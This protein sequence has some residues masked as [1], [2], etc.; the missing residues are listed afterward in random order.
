[1]KLLLKK[2]RSISIFILAISLMG[3][4]DDDENKLPKVV[5]GF[6]QTIDEDTGTTTFINIST[7]ANTYLWDFGDEETSTEIN[8]VKS[9]AA[10]GTYTVT[11]TATNLAGLSD[12]S[13]AELI[14]VIKDL[15]ALPV[16]F[17]DPNVIYEAT[18][19]EGASFDVVDN[20]DPSG[21][22]ADASQVGEITNSG[23]AFEGL[24]FDLGA[25]LDLATDQT[26][27]MDFW[28]EAVLEVLIK[29][30][31]GSGSDVE[32]SAS[33]SGSG[34]ET[35]YF[36]FTSVDKFSRMTLFVDGPGTAAGTFYFD[37][38][39]QTATICRDTELGLPIDF[40]CESTTY[41]FVTTS[42]ATYQVI[43][44]PELSG[45]NNAATNV[46]EIVTT[47]SAGGTFTLDN[48]IDL[49]TVAAVS[50]KMFSATGASATVKLENATTSVETVVVHGGTGWERL[51]FNYTAS[52]EMYDMVTLTVDAAGTYYV[53]DI[54]QSDGT[55]VTPPVVTIN[56]GVSTINL[57]VGDLFTDP[58]ATA[59]DDEDGPVAVVVTGVADVDVNTVGS[60]DVI[61][62]ATDAAGNIGQAT[63]T[64]IVSAAAGCTDTILEV[65]IDFDCESTTYDFVTFNGAS[66]QVIDNPQLS[67]INNVASKVGEIVNIGGGFEGGAFTLGNPV[68]FSTDKSITMKVYATVAVP[69]LLKF[70]GA[71]APIET[72][73]NHGGSG[74]EQLTFDFASSD[75]FNTLVVFVDGPGT[76]A[77]TFYMD[78]IEQIPTGGGGCTDTILEVPIDF[79]CESTTYDFVTF[80]GASYQVIDNPQLSGINNVASKVG[81]IVNIGGAFEGGAFTL[82]NPIDFSTDKSITMKV[83][84]TVAVPILLKFEGA[85]APIETTANHGGAGWEQ[86]TFD[87]AS[88]DQFTTLVLFVDGPGTTAGTFY[89]DDIE[90]IPTGGGGGPCTDTI[91]EVPIDFDCESLTY[92]FVTFNG[93]SYQVIDNPQL[94]GINNVASKV[95]EIVNIGGAFE[96][97]AFTLGNPV[98]FSTDKSI[99]M[100]VY[101]TVAVPIL[102]KFEGA[103]A[104]IET[105]ANH[106][107]AGWEQL[108]F[109]FTSS[110]Q[111]TT[112]VLFVDGPGTTAGTFYMDDIEQIPTGG[113]GGPAGIVNGDFETGDDT[114]W[115]FF[116]NGGTTAVTNAESTGPG[117][118]SAKITSGPTNNPGIKQ[119]RFGEGTILPNQQYQVTLDSNIETLVDGA[120]INVLAFSET[121]SGGGAVLHNLGS[122]NT[123]TG[124]WNANTFNFTTAADVTGGVSLLIEVVCGGA[125]TCS[126]VAY[127]DNVTFTIN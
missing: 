16:S 41:D 34:W 127:F 83:Y 108:T 89:M 33:H 112:L 53:D 7:N 2:A 58:G 104:P 92:D 61:Y 82:G 8:P 94:S 107:G 76:T 54:I 50:L 21:S 113:G 70:E 45:I 28:S 93:A 46:A 19:F 29:L 84:A 11:L 55:D 79:D 65:P 125:G 1:M 90:Q 47:E 109:D 22:N 25:Q 73:A 103:G 13:E 91:L 12:V 119:E 126:G 30:E 116:D 57:N 15:I 74:W 51:T 17:D 59:E 77:G 18:T 110:D 48:S 66:Y 115:L 43:A 60:Y 106:G 71:G 14:I 68:D 62:S 85:G 63:L 31:E 78:D 38:I 42:G 32:T 3:C 123:A 23:A 35:I 52:A 95:G 100:K 117:T 72:T 99:T 4:L 37:N 81:E 44:N 87:F 39:E 105:T 6:T 69:I 124:S 114:G 9:Y 121:N 98:D 120:I 20:P 40:D 122:V 56:G 101:A 26:I 24:Y 64:V 36:D 27:A 118:F 111:F 49:S 88:S 86:L 67:G 10:A 75:S 97:G 5:S 102:L 80:N 96:G